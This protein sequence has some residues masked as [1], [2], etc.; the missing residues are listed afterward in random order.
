M[1]VPPFTPEG[2]LA[3][4]LP[5]GA[6]P[7][8]IL[9]A[10]LHAFGDTVALFPVIAGLAAR[11]PE[12]RLEVVTG[13]PS[14]ALFR[15]RGDV[16]AVHVL[17]ARAPGL[18]PYA[19]A[20]RL[21]RALRREPPDAFVDLQRS[22]LTRALR[23]LLRP[24]S[25]SVFDRFA[26]RHGLD[27]YLDAVAACGLGRPEPVFAP[28]AREAVSARARALLARCGRDASRPL[29]CLNPAGGWPTKQWPVE[30]WGALGRALASSHG[31]QI[32]LLGSGEAAARVA[33]LARELPGALDLVGRTDAPE[34]M[35]LVAGC[36]AVVS[37]DSGLLHLAWTQGIP[38]V[39]LFG[40]TRAAWCRPVGPAA[41]GFYSED[42]ACGACMEPVCARGDLACL[43]RVSVDEVLARVA[44]RRAG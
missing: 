14:A 18:A 2:L 13:P 10:R 36:A 30:R 27:R 43:A 39:A 32:L 4:P 34:A 41:D 33:A 31:A 44:P 28:G 12:C 26:P 11:F 20:A 3:R 19:E 6:A 21:S 23:L 37:E 24:R 1:P 35:A 7:R 9:L 29:V 8:R 42:L 15:A 40:A 17:D 5:P 16:A 22:R 38:T 25:F